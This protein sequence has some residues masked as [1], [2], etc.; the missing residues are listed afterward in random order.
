MTARPESC[1]IVQGLY[2]ECPLQRWQALQT[3][4]ICVLGPAL[5]DGPQDAMVKQRSRTGPQSGAVPQH[6]GQHSCPGLWVLLCG[7]REWESQVDGC[8]C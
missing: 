1:V 7:R 4:C 8:I 2:L 6:R 5:D 3:D